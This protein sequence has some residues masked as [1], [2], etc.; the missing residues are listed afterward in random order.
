M[1]VA[2][3]YELDG[4]TVGATELSVPNGGTTLQ[5]L[6]TN[7]VFQLWIDPVQ[8]GA[9]TKGDYFRVRVYEKCLSGSTKRV[10]FAADIGNAQAEPWILPPL[11]LKHGWDM[12][13]QKLAGT[14]RAFDASIRG[15]SGTITQAYS[16]SAVS[17][18]TTA[19]SIVSGDTIDQTVAEPGTYQLFV[20]GVAAG[21]AKGDDFEIVIEEKV[22]A[23]GG[24]KRQIFSARLMDVQS[25]LFVSPMFNLMHGWDM[26]IR[27]VAGTNRN[28]DASIRKVS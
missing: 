11:M 23:T 21:M 26:T 22:E 10:V 24:G 3:L 20:D 19:V 16:I 2:E 18:S 1:P 15:V 7:G 5:N 13:I 14:D 6:T 4:V 12:T 25:Q 17:V 8:G 9:M 28:F 27:K